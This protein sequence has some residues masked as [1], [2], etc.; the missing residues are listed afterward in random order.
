MKAYE[1]PMWEEL[2]KSILIDY[3]ITMRVSK[4][5][6]RI[7]RIEESSEFIYKSVFSKPYKTILPDEE[8]KNIQMLP[9]SKEDWEF[10]KWREELDF[11]NSM[12][13]KL[14]KDKVYRNKFV[15]IKD[16]KLIDSDIDNF[17]LVKRVNKKYHN[18]V[19]LIVKVE[20]GIRMAEIPSPEVYL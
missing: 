7:K 11:F 17:R 16:K 8:Y 6:E 10:S 19:V 5:E 4:L 3:A 14:L 1:S 2:S 20:K 18:D 12:K 9:I 15:A 13:K